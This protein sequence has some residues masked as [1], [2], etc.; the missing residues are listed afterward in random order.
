MKKVMV[1]ALFLVAGLALAADKVSTESATSTSTTTTT[2]SDKDLVRSFGGFP[3]ETSGSS[4]GTRS[5]T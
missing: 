4:R 3:G 1:I 2:K 5:G